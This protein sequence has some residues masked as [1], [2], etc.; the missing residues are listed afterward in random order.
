NIGLTLRRKEGDASGIPFLRRAIE[1]DP[2]FPLAYSELAL[3][4]DNLEQPSRA[5]EYASKAYQLRDRATLREQLSIT[6]LYFGA[7]GELD[8]EIQTYELWTASYP[9][10]PVPRFNLGAD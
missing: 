10:N 1:L 9:R 4:Y 2:N 7:T 6:A 8:K 3:S 5:L